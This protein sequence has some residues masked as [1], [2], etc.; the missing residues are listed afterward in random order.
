MNCV[1]SG[2]IDGKR[3][4]NKRHFYWSSFL[5]LRSIVNDAH[6][7]HLVVKG[8]IIGLNTVPGVSEARQ[9]TEQLIR[10]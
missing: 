1:Q 6:R 8:V 4:L 3:L 9:T 2:I 10:F 7:S 5:S